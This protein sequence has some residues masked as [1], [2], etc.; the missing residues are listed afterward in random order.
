MLESGSQEVIGNRNAKLGELL[1]MRVNFLL[2]VEL[3]VI[4]SAKVLELG[5]AENKV[6]CDEHGMSHS[7]GRAIFASMRNQSVILCV[8]EAVR[9][10]PG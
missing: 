5:T 4:V 2:A 9:V 3:A 8:E 6:D 10:L 1:D 7:H